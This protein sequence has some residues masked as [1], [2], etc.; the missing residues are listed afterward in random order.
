M[1]AAIGRPSGVEAATVREQAVAGIPSG[2]FSTPKEVATL[3][4]LLASPCTANVTGANYVIG[5][6]LVKTA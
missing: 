2:R 1:A 5:R 3:V 4:V 6:G